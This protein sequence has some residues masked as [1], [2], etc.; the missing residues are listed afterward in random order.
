MDKNPW[1]MKHTFKLSRL[2]LMVIIA[3]LPA[4]PVAGQ[5][6][7]TQVQAEIANLQK[8][9]KEKPITDPNF[10]E[11]SPMIEGSLNEAEYALHAG[12]LYLSLE[13]LGIASDLLQGVRTVGEKTSVVKSGL[14]AFEAEW[15]QVSKKLAALD[16]EARQ[17]SWKNSP[18]AVQ[19]LS[20]VAQG[21]S[22]PLL[23]GGRGFAISTQPADGL[24]YLGQAEGNAEFA[25]FCS[26]LKFAEIREPIALRSLL[27]ELQG[28]QEKTDVAY[29]PP[30]SV[31]LH[32]RF[33]QL[34][35]AL[36]LAQE[37]DATKFYAGALLEYLESVRHFGM[38]SAPPI[39]AARQSALK[40]SLAAEHK[41]LA[42]SQHDE[43]LA[44]LFLERAESQTTHADG[45][46]PSADEWKSASVILDQVLP[47][48]YR[49][50]KPAVP[51]EL[52][53]GKTVNITLVRWPYT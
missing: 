22:I 52:T 8:S 11:M 4:L 15:G 9:L 18:L 10:A 51:V 32:P 41:K 14:P 27:P 31:E 45:S 35:S 19:A 12:R 40:E 39:D 7:S 23:D 2:L 16:Y 48:Y 13:K 20:E 49:A 36:K 26:A 30:R 3:A 37:L 5:D 25:K 17:R 42:K 53:S 6:A 38:L 50:Q 28:L 21:K 29:Q 1:K 34:N 44:E 24:F 46:A 33:I 43:S 47:A